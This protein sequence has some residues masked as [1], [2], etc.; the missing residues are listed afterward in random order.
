MSHLKIVKDIAA[1]NIKKA[2]VKQKEQYDKKTTTPNFRIGQSV[3]MHTTRVPQ[4]LSPKLHNPWDGPFYIAAIGPNNTYKI[5]RC[6]THKELKSYIHANRLKAYN[7]PTH[8]PL[9]DP[10]TDHSRDNTHLPPNTN[11]S[12]TNVQNQD[13]GDSQCSN[14]PVSAP[15][16]TNSTQTSSQSQ[17]SQA[18][19]SSNQNTSGQ[20]PTQTQAQSQTPYHVEKL[21]RYKYDKGKKI[22][23]VQWVGYSERTWEPEENLPPV[24]VR[25]FHITKTQRGTAKKK[26]KKGLN[27]FKQKS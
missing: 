27:C 20:S 19:Q 9:L 23:R 21:L 10:P 11:V 4:G 7:N 24:L 26:K 22:F 5:R 13:N 8:R 2:Q 15:T 3:L 1:Q 12:D 14:D 18:S 25:Q 17:S 16:D 6:S